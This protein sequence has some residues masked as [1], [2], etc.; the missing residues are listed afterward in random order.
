MKSSN[1]SCSAHTAPRHG[2][3]RLHAAASKD[4]TSHGDILQQRGITPPWDP[5]DLGSAQCPPALQRRINLRINFVHVL[6]IRV[7][8]GWVLAHRHRVRLCTYVLQQASK[9]K[10]CM[11]YASNVSDV[12]RHARLACTH[13]STYGEGRLRVLMKQIDDMSSYADRHHQSRT[14]STTSLAAPPSSDHLDHKTTSQ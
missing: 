11:I 2:S 7:C 4:L 5:M 13:A 6:R 8:A 3:W 12:H 9:R 14:T 10:A 1:G